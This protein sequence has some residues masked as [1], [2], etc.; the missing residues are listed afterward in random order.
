MTRQEATDLATRINQTWPR[1]LATTVW[2]EEL[3]PL[4][5][6]RAG[7]AIARLRRT[8]QTLSIARFWTEY[9]TIN[10]TDG[11]TRP[12]IAD[13]NLCQNTG[14]APVSGMVKCADGTML[15]MDVAVGPCTCPRGRDMENTLRGIVDGNQAELDRLFPNRHQEPTIPKWVA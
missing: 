3:A 2:E 9:R 4:D 6:G 15:E 5:A 1:G 13:C 14:T 11:S 7:T 8:E 12:H 10:T